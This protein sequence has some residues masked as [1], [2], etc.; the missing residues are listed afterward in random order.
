MTDIAQLGSSNG[1]KRRSWFEHGRSVRFD[2]AVERAFETDVANE[3]SEMEM[4]VLTPFM[5]PPVVD[6]GQVTVGQTKSCQL[7]VRNP[8]NYRQQVIST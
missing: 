4:L 2:I 1:K 7:C 3:E 8:H 5:K 6:F